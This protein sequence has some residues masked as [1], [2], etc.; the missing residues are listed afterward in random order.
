MFPIMFK[1]G[2]ALLLSSLRIPRPQSGRVQRAE[3]PRKV[4]DSWP[5]ARQVREHGQAEIRPQMRL[6]PVREQSTSASSPGQRARKQ[7]VHIR[8]N[9]EA[10]TGR[11][12]AA[13]TEMVIPQ[14]DR[15]CELAVAAVRP[16]TGLGCE[17]DQARNC[18]M[19]HIAVD[20]LSPISFP[21]RIRHNPVYVLL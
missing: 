15:I 20:I 13:A 4:V 7:S 6:I 12:S 5:Q 11:E 3:Q 1:T 17:P 8:G 10:S 21:V 16:Q 9:D 18:S 14:P 19:Q 2:Q